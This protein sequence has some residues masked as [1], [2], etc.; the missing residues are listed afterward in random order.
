MKKKPLPLAV[1]LL[2]ISSRFATGSDGL[3]VGT[4]TTLGSWDGVG[5][6]QPTAAVSHPSGS[7]RVFAGKSIVVDSDEP[8]RRVSI[9]DPAIA[10][11]TII[12]PNQVLIHGHRSGNVT[13]ILWDE[14][15]RSRT[16]DLQVEL[17]L[18]YLQQTLQ[19][20]LPNE[21][22]K[23]SQSG[24]SIVISGVASSQRVMEQAVALAQAHSE[25]VVN[26][27]EEQSDQILLQVRFAEVDRAAIQELGVSF[28]TTGMQVGNE[29]FM[30]SLSTQQFQSMVGN[31][32]AAPAEAQRGSVPA[33]NIASGGVGNPVEG[34]P[35]VFGLSD[36][37]NL[38][39]FS[40]GRNI[41]IVIKALEQRNLLQILAEPNLLAQNGREASFLAGGEFPFPAVQGLGGGL[42]AVTIQFREF[43][44]RLNFTP[45][46]LSNDE[47][48]LK[49]VQ[50]VSALDFANAL[51]ISGFV[52]PALSTRR[53]ET[54]LHL[55]DGQTFAIAG[56]IDNRFI[57][58]ASKIPWLGDIPILGKLFQS[59]KL[60]Q[61]N[62]ELVVMVT[63]RRVKP[64]EPGE[65]SPDPEFPKPF[66]DQDKF[67][68]KKQGK[69]EKGAEQEGQEDK[70]EEEPFAKPEVK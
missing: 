6:S 13:L 23:V 53:A 40:P 56:L 36:L 46:I 70:K 5:N 49:V 1:I 33:P 48:S 12:G 39:V 68:Q 61:R 59:R 20:V 51:T 15:E 3:P 19:Q 21:N 29:N 17:D 47:I 58:V 69:E 8:L 34:Q 44:V 9:T 26:L 67:D 27:L 52:V 43:G 31:V 50:E 65:P 22:I 25:N 18:S 66:L 41:G 62:T 45:T 37:F 64:L 16:Y 60:E 30:G 32:G 28:F 55:R 14:Q 35:A 2:L 7:L 54:E 38:F 57:E 10:S 24:A 42:P 11:A 63:P 4:E